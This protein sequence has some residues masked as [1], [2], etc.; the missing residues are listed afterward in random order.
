MRGHLH[1]AVSHAFSEIFTLWHRRQESRLLPK[2]GPDVAGLTRKKAPDCCWTTSVQVPGR[3][4]KKWPTVVVEVGW[5]EGPGK[6]EKDAL[7]WLRESQQDVKVALTINITRRGSVTVQ[8][9]A[10]N[11]PPCRSPVK[12]I[13]T[14]HITRGRGADSDQHQIS[15]SLHVPFGDCFLRPKRG[16]ETDFVLSNDD[17]TEIAEDVW[18][19]LPE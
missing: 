18:S 19:C 13:Q 8:R 17:I 3:D 6:L 9:W 5:S 14:M 12:L 11:P 1:E 10:L 7:F 4:P 16:N 2:G 15:G